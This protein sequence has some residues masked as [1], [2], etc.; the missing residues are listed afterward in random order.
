M[1]LFELVQTTGALS[2]VLCLTIALLSVKKQL[3]EYIL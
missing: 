2:G 3:K 1:I